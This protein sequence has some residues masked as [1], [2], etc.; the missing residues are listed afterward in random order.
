LSVFPLK[1]H[2]ILIFLSKLGLVRLLAPQH[3]PRMLGCRCKDGPFDFVV[4][5]ASCDSQDSQLGSLIAE[6]W[7]EEVRRETPAVVTQALKYTAHPQLLQSPCFHCLSSAS[8]RDFAD[9]LV[10]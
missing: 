7:S 2:S 5:Q 6:V 9:D 8:V 3:L 4:L 10:G 1:I